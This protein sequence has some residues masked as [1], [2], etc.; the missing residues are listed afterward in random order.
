MRDF[1]QDFFQGI[2]I[3]GL[4]VLGSAF[5]TD[6]GIMAII[7]SLVAFVGYAITM[8]LDINGTIARC[9]EK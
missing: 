6:S 2:V 3:C 1:F 7:G 9:K 8:L 4:V 5:I